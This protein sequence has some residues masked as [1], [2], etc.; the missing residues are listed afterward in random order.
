MSRRSFKELRPFLSVLIIITTL[1]GV[2]FLKMDLRRVGYQVLKKTREYKKLR[3]DHRV[4]VMNYAKITTP[5]RVR[6]FAISKLPLSDARTGQII[7][8]TGQNIA[9]PQ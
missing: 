7:Q 5:A 6:K 2:A 8:L 1:F 4:L 9:V 3:D